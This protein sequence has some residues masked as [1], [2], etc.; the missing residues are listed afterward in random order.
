MVNQR[1]IVE[2]MFDNDLGGNHPAVVLSNRL[3]QEIEG[4][5]VCVMMTSTAQND[6][7]SFLI[8]DDM[9]IKPLNI[10][11]CE[12]RCHLINFVPVESIIRNANNNQLR[13]APFKQLLQKIYNSTFSTDEL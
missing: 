11:H 9:L 1:D 7:F 12:V 8:T 4:Y 2:I 3:V 6:E 5:M 10:D 13:I